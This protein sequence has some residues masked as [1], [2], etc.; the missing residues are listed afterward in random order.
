M[1]LE[2]E[3]VYHFGHPEPDFFICINGLSLGLFMTKKL[4]AVVLVSLDFTTSGLTLLFFSCKICICA[5][6]QNKQIAVVE[7]SRL[8]VM[9]IPTLQADPA[10]VIFA[11]DA[12]HMIAPAIF[13]HPRLTLWTL[14]RVGLHP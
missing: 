12:L 6:F 2:L 8:S 1:R 13:L 10:E 14:F 7:S 3:M 5:F 9:I 4:E 11:F